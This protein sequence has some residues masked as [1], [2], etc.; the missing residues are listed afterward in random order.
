MQHISAVPPLVQLQAITTEA[1]RKAVTTIASQEN[2]VKEHEETR[3]IRKK[4]AQAFL[5]S[6]ELVE[7]DQRPLT[8]RKTKE[9]V[10]ALDSATGLKAKKVI[11]AM[12]RGTKEEKEVKEEGIHL[13]TAVRQT[14][15][16]IV[17]TQEDR[18]FLTEILTQDHKAEVVI[19][20]DLAA[21]EIAVLTKESLLVI[22]R[23]SKPKKIVAARRQSAAQLF[24]EQVLQ[25]KFRH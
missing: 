17:M 14:R 24:F 15:E 22:T 4:K 5:A 16:E 6:L 20:T 18:D 25:R 1:D 2:K 21:L 12:V 19:S 9:K 11:L 10:A 3:D 13:L 7:K 8:K 23:N